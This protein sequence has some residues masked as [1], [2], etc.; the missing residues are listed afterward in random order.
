MILNSHLYSMPPI[1]QYYDVVGSI[2]INSLSKMQEYKIDVENKIYKWLNN[3]CNFGKKIYKSDIVK[4][5]N[6]RPE[7]T[8]VD[9]DIKVSDIIKTSMIDYQFK[10]NLLSVSD[11]FSFNRNYIPS[12]MYNDGKPYFNMVT[13]PKTDSNGNRITKDMILGSNTYVYVSMDNEKKNVIQSVPKDVMETEENIII[14]FNAVKEQEISAFTNESILTISLPHDKD[15]ASLSN[16][17]D[18]NYKEYNLSSIDMVNKIRNDIVEWFKNANKITH[19]DRAIPLP[20]YISNEI[21][22]SN[23]RTEDILRLGTLQTDES[24]QLT[25]KAFW[26]YMV[27]QIINKYYKDAINSDINGNVWKGIDRLVYDLYTSLKVVFADS[28]LDDNNNII[29]YTMDN[30]LPVIRLNLTYRYGN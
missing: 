28:I 27:P 26:N 7:T 12:D 20:Y 24:T 23:S 30:E 9:I 25:E 10:L 11:V 6:D 29:N 15:F 21:T 3:T 4:F 17:S 14:L 1:V 2:Y 18:Y 22:E 16:F 8:F 13:I 19:V 5:F